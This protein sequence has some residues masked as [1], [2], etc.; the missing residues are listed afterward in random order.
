LTGH[1][2]RGDNDHLQ[3]RLYENSAR[4]YEMQILHGCTL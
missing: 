1:C 3:I 4:L 2:L